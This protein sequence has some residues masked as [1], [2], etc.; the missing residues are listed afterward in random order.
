M[1]QLEEDEENTRTEQ[2]KTTRP[3]RFLQMIHCIYKAYP[4]VFFCVES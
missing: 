1:F 4:C 2:C 3:D